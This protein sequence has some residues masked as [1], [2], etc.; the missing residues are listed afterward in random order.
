ME[1]FDSMPYEE[2]QRTE[3]WYDMRQK[4]LVI[5][6]FCC[7]ICGHAASENDRLQLHHIWYPER[8]RENVEADLVMLCRRCHSLVSKMQK[9]EIAC[10]EAEKAVTY[11][12]GAISI[13]NEYYTDS[14]GNWCARE[15]KKNNIIVPA[16]RTNKAA[17][18]LLNAMYGIN[19]TNR[20]ITA[21]MLYPDPDRIFF[22]NTNL[23]KLSAY[24]KIQKAIKWAREKVKKA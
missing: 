9:G 16:E 15:L 19:G 22:T 8:G 14:L 10:R 4:R 13:L 5:D 11:A 18:V 2:Y 17:S 24:N 3:Y 21:S 7:A 23:T 1:P 20:S 6:D 12:E